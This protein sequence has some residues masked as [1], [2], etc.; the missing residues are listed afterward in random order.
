MRLIT[1]TL[2]VSRSNIREQLDKVP[3]LNIKKNIDDEWLLPLIKEITDSRPTYGYRRVNAILN[4]KLMAMN[5]EKVNHK[6]IYRIMKENHLLLTRYGAKRMQAHD[7]KVMTLKSN[8]RWC[9]DS[10]SIQ[11]FNGDRVHVAFAMDTCDRE[12]MSYVASTIGTNGAAIRDLMVECVEKRF[13]KTAVLPHQV[14]WLSDNGPC[15]T[16]HETVGFARMIGFDVRTTPSYSPESNGMAEALVKTIKRDYAWFA[17]LKDAPTVMGQLNN[18][19]E[20]YNENA[21]HKGLKM[22]SPR[23]F[24][25]ENL[26]G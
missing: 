3:K 4:L 19:F 6:R 16:S 26:A 17:D 10:F 15:Y 24:I 13:G 9:S 1:E 11:C 12:V 14:Q 23:Q 7:G 5:K 2:D 18:W 25:R 20:D 22:K 21:P 8:T